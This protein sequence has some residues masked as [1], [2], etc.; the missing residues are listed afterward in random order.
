MMQSFVEKTLL[1]RSDLM[2][3]TDKETRVIFPESTRR[4]RSGSPPF[5]RR[6]NC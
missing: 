1:V 3:G 4:R 2:H 5:D 6:R